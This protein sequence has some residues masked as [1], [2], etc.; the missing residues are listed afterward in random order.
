MIT[1]KNI[2][3]LTLSGL[4][5]YNNTLKKVTYYFGWYLVSYGYDLLSADKIVLVSLKNLNF[6]NNKLSSNPQFIY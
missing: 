1:L 3:D 6:I 2:N 5:I 4:K